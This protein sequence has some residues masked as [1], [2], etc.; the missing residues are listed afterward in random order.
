VPADLDD[1][2][3]H[4]GQVCEWFL[5]QGS[6]ILLNGQPIG[7]LNFDVR[8]FPPDYPPRKAFFRVNLAK[9]GKLDV[10]ITAGLI[11]D[12]RPED[13]NYGVYFYCKHRLVV[14]E[15]KVRDVG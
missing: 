14:K 11:L 12:R 7:P 4:F 2:V 10:V 13:D 3:I 5:Q 9:A 8:A 15:L 6:T 1:L